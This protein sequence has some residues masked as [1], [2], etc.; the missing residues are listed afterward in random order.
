MMKPALRHNAPAY[1]PPAYQ[2]NQSRI[3]NAEAKANNTSDKSPHAPPSANGFSSNGKV[4][5]LYLSGRCM[6]P[7]CLYR[8]DIT[9]AEAER[10]KATV[11][12]FGKQCVDEKCVFSHPAPVLGYAQRE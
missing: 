5:F 2:S 12:R 11:C 6:N 4:C 9:D 3:D 8:H 1:V 7:A 10:I